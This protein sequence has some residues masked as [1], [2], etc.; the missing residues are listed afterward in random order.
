[1][2]QI[3]F[4]LFFIFLNGWF[5]PLLAQNYYAKERFEKGEVELHVG[6][7]G[8]AVKYYDQAIGSY[9]KY[10]AAFFSRGKAH[11]HLEQFEKAQKDFEKVFALDA[12]RIDALFYKG[13]ILYEQQYFEK[14]IEV[15]DQAL[16]RDPQ[17]AIVYNYRAECYRELGLNSQAIKDYSEAIRL[18]SLIPVLYLGRGKCYLVS[19]NYA[20]ATQDFSKAIALEPRK[21]SYYRYRAEAQYLHGAYA[22]ASEDMD[23]LSRQAESEVQIHEYRLN[24]FCKASVQDYAGAARVITEL[25]RKAP[26]D[27]EAL[28]E[29][30][31]YYTKQGKSA[32]AIQDFEKALQ[33]QPENIE[34]H[35]ACARLYMHTEQYQAAQTHLRVALEKNLEDA[36]IW[37]LLGLSYFYLEEKSLAKQH[38]IKAATLDY[39]AEE[40]PKK[41]YKLAKKGYRKRK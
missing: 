30:A 5:S 7:F 6:D 11:Y 38:L 28:T 13:V 23:Y 2:S 21:L 8:E 14:A 31:V 22:L 19:E 34:N 10:T 26:D 29:R 20:D 15:F 4:L 17:Y 9:Q 39:P 1:M 41:V 37:Y 27:I 36:E 35:L 25:L 18:D 32:E 3:K 24:A 16:S 12:K 33:L 40:M